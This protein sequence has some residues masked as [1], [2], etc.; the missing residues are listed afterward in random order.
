MH[1]DPRAFWR[2]F[3]QA[4]HPAP[5]PRITR[6]SGLSVFGDDG[7]EYLDAISGSY[8]HCFGHGDA[9]LLDAV[10]RQMHRLVHFCSVTGDTG[11]TEELAAT[12]V[13]HLAVPGLRH[14]FL[15]LSGSEGIET[16]LK[17][18]WQFHRNRGAARQKIASLADAYHGCT[19][20]ALYATQRGFCKDGLPFV[21]GDDSLAVPP[22]HQGGDLEVWRELLERQGEAIAAIVVEP[23]MGLAGAIEQPPGFLRGLCALARQHGVLVIADEVFC[24][25]GRAGSL[26]EAAAQ[27]AEPDIVVFSKCLGGGFPITATVASDSVFAGFL[28]DSMDR[29]FRSGHTQTGN[30]LGCAAALHVLRRIRDEDWCGQVRRAGVALREALESA[31]TGSAEVATVRGKGLM[32]GIECTSFDACGAVQARA[33][34]QGLLVGTAGKVVKVAPAFPISSQQSAQLV[35]LLARSAR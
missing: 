27:G 22:P 5:L 8:N 4:A 14:V 16:A 25:I 2:P 3:D 30:L 20:G 15:T 6:G 11:L 35:E 13:E 10:Q 19:M 24:G 32:L 26:C 1:S 7:T 23:V 18:A 34:A 12:L 28:G 29:A 21:S 17:M 9:Q 33:R 31:L